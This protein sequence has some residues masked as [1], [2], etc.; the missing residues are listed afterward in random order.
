MA[1]LEL[2]TGLRRGEFCALMWD[3]L[4]MTT[5]ELRIERQVNRLDG[6]LHVSAP[7][8]DAAVRTVILPPSVVNVLREY[9]ETVDS[10]WM[11][12]SPVRQCRQLKILSS[13]LTNK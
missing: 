7:K 11:F 6:E 2:A 13:E 3:D 10:R 1:L 12:P 8:T 9:R 5:G 4:D